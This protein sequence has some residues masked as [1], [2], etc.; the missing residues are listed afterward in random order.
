M[1]GE[2][3][4]P[5]PSPQ[6][7]VDEMKPRAIL[8]LGAIAILGVVGSLVLVA[9]GPRFVGFSSFVVTGGSM[10][11]SIQKGAIAI[12]KPVSPASLAA[13]DVVVF[14]TRTGSAPTIHRIVAI[15]AI[16]GAWSITTKGDAN[17]LADPQPLVVRQ[18]G[19][20]IVYSVPYA[21]YL[22]ELP[23]TVLSPRMAFILP[24]LALG[25]LTLWS[26]WKPA[27]QLTPSA[28]ET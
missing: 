13:G 3:P 7:W 21:G 8:Q 18:E 23:R 17:D 6:P 24:A 2:F 28:A 15:E 27:K 9:V 20:R 4:P 14:K 22:L 10:E 5:Q 12:G 25:V 16:D 11:P 19:S 1:V 26:I